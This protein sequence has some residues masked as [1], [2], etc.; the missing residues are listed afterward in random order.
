MKVDLNK[1]FLDMDESPIKDDSD[2]PLML[3]KILANH[4]LGLGKENV[5]KFYDWGFSLWKDGIIDVDRTDSEMLQKFI[6]NL[7]GVTRLL[8]GR[9]LAEFEKK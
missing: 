2:K 1:P 7:D 8:K 9:L 5:M 3:N 6:E 4:L